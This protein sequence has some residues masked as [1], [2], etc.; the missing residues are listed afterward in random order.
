MGREVIE[1]AEVKKMY[2][3]KEVAQ[4]L[5]LKNPNTVRR[6]I[7]DRELAS[8]RVGRLVRI[9]QEDLDDFIQRNRQP[10]RTE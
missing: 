5:G 3:V 8:V 9:S 2:G 7:D 4:I 1:M 10:A 6:L